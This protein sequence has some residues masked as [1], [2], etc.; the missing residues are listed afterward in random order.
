MPA[1]LLSFFRPAVAISG[2]WSSQEIA[3]FYRVE[4]ALVQA[5]VRVFVDRGVTDEGDPWFVFCRETDGEVI[6]HF[7]RI[8]GNYLIAA[9][10]IGPPIRGPDFRSAMAQLGSRNITANPIWSSSGVT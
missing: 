4:A 5:G 3:E 7:A 10:S 9:E 6:V 2:D 1:E 8:N